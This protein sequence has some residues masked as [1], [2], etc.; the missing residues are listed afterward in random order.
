[1]NIILASHTPVGVYREYY[2][3]MIICPPFALI[4]YPIFTEPIGTNMNNHF[5]AN[6][7]ILYAFFCVVLLQVAL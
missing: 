1:M 3:S 6:L 2:Q 4:L 5:L 7:Y